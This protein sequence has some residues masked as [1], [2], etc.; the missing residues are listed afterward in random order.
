[1]KI[2]LTGLFLGLSLIVFVVMGISIPVI[3][4]VQAT[5]LYGLSNFT[6][7]IPYSATRMSVDKKSGEIYVIYENLLKV[8]NPAGMEIYHFGE[9]L[10]VGQILDLTVVPNGD[11]LL[12]TVK[13]SRETLVQCNYRG[14]PISRID[15]KKMPPEFSG[16]VATRLVCHGDSL[17]FA[18]GE[19]MK[20]VITDLEGNF[21]KGY[22]LISLLELK[23][24]DRGN[25]EIYGFS[26]DGN[27]NIL[28]TIAVLFKAFVLSDEGKLSYFGK[29][30][31]AP[32]KFNIVSGI[33]RDSQGNFLVVDRLKSAV[34]I[35]DK[36]F[37]FVT[38]FG[39][40]GLRPENLFAPDDIAIDS[41]DRI[42]VTQE[43]KRGISVF[44]LTHN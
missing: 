6:G 20:I 28:F 5:Y 27:G 24:E 31:G 44:K 10:D 41:N 35:F 13:D 30:G 33:V 37:N 12:L 19:G 15:L 14:D 1:M 32:G 16:F 36:K 43:R 4:N 11:L 34:M 8:F 9:D 17:Y 3:A 25:M 23:E 42:Y 39:F 21:K 26:V 22:D 40:R 7:K 29:A 38:Q 2:K 18:S